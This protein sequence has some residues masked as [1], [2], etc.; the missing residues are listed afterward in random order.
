MERHYRVFDAVGGTYRHG[1]PRHP[2]AHKTDCERRVGQSTERGHAVAAD[3]KR[4]GRLF[5][6]WLWQ[7][8][9]I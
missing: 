9:D 2:I 4:A 8:P 7:V 5:S 1:I 6:G 3:H